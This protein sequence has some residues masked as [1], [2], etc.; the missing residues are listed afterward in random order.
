MTIYRFGA[1]A[2]A[3][4]RG[5]LFPLVM[6]GLLGLWALMAM[7]ISCGPKLSAIKSEASAART[8]VTCEPSDGRAPGSL[9]RCIVEP[10]AA[11]ARD[12]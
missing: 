6:A 10:D 5:P 8:Y 9:I 4:E 11:N 3:T 7:A 1:R 2:G 12:I